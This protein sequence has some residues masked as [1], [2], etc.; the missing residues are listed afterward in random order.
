MA[1]TQVANNAKTT[2]SAGCTDVATAITPTAKTTFPDPEDDGSFY[3]TIWDADTYPDPGDDPGMEIVLVTADAAA[4][5]TV[6]RG[7]AGTAGAAHVA[8]DAVR[9]LWLAE[10]ATEIRDAVDLNTAHRVAGI[11]TTFVDA[12]GNTITV[13][14]G[15]ITAKTAP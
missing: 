13:S 2:L 12:D 8:G 5:W 4:N 10:H 15:I 14:G 9:L 1:W 11:D 6:T 7:Q 3:V